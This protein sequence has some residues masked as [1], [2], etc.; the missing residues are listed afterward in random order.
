MATSIYDLLGVIADLDAALSDNTVDRK[1]AIPTHLKTVDKL[2]YRVPDFKPDLD[3]LNVSEPLTFSNHLKGQIVILDFFTYCCINCMHIL[4]DLEAVEKEF[5]PQSGVVVIGVHSAKFLNEKVTANILS[6]VLRYNI[7]HPVVNDS[8]AQMW[9]ALAVSCWPTLVF[10]GPSGQLI[11]SLAG[12]GH[13]S[14]IL[15]FLR[16]AVEHYSSH[17]QHH[18]LPLSLERHKTPVSSLSFPG[19]VCFWPERDWLVVAD[20]GNHRIVVVDKSGVVQF[21]VGSG[22]S[23][24]KDGDFTSA[25]FSAP[26]GVTCDQSC[27]YVADTGNH[28]VRKIDLELKRVVTLVGTGLQ[29]TDKEGGKQHKDQEIASPWDVVLGP[30]LDEGSPVLFIAMAGTHQIWVYFF[31]NSTWYHGKSYATG[32]C[33][34]FAGSGQEE[35]RNN[36]YAEKA[37]FAQPSGLAFSFKDPSR[38]L[39]V[40]D[41]ESSSIRT[42]SLAKGAVAGLVGGERDPKNLFAYGDVDGKG[43]QAKLQHPLGVAYLNGKLVVADSYNHKIK[44]ID[45]ETL[46]CTTFAGTGHQGST[47]DTSDLTKCQFN[48]PGGVAVD[49][50]DQMIYVA[51]TNNHAIK[52]ISLVKKTIYQLPIVFPSDK[53]ANNNPEKNTSSSQLLGNSRLPRDEA[54]PLPDVTVPTSSRTVTLTVPLKLPDGSH[55]NKD[56]P[57]SWKICS[58]D[59][60][61][62]NLLDQKGNLHSVASDGLS[63]GLAALTFTLPQGIT[64]GVYTIK[65]TVQIFVC[66]DEEDVCLPPSLAHFKQV[67]KLT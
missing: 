13:R 47:L 43:F 14:W 11:Y 48:E 45:L 28:C 34:R 59:E 49:E 62:A 4:P 58:L 39:Y 52:A 2:N 41:S 65:V 37:S 54:V 8:D 27:I 17:L 46:M 44:L 31:K 3:W 15:E 57:N 7:Q 26:Q 22:H 55:I 53:E 42:V 50:H 18:S 21:V 51:D 66:L 60:P 23:G 6:A 19:K 64:P 63:K 16:L 38:R 9:Q 36:S 61:S 20:T 25:E 29:G 56:A 5:P 12:E 10:L 67:L 40:A 33:I 35:N 24:L 30:S 32:T 1:Q